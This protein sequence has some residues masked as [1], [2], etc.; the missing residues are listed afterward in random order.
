[1][2]SLWSVY[3]FGITH[4]PMH[5]ARLIHLPACHKDPFDR[6]LAAQALVEEL[7]LVSAD[8]IFDGYDVPRI[9]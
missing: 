2:D 3:G 6:L 7:P 4:Y 9:W 1:M 5:T 8:G